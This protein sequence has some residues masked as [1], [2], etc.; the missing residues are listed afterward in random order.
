MASK[1][2]QTALSLE[3]IEHS[4]VSVLKN[5]LLDKGE[6]VAEK[7]ARALRAILVSFYFDLVARSRLIAAQVPICADPWF[8]SGCI[9]R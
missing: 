9:L 3:Q 4:I 6:E 7:R 2:P 5:G 1:I 8:Q